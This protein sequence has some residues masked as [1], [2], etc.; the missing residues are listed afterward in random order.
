MKTLLAMVA[1]GTALSL[2]S[3]VP[4]QPQYPPIPGA[5]P[6]TA[7]MTPAP[8]YSPTRPSAT[9]NRLP[10]SPSASSGS[11]STD[12]SRP[13]RPDPITIPSITPTNE[14]NY[15]TATPGVKPNTVIS[16]YA[17]Y[18]VINVEGFKSGQ[19]A[20]DTSTI[21]ID[22][23]TGKPYVD[24]SGQPDKSKAKIFIVP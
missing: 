12:P 17:P 18:N 22:P 9:P 13:Y 6:G 14:S 2:V 1:A 11:S 24:A 7:P 19:K 16:P 15:L 3:C 21:P 10:T 20:Y 4:Y 8:D 23:A 5:S